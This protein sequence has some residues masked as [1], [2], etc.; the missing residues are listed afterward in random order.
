MQR[1]N[2]FVYLSANRHYLQ[3]MLNVLFQTAV[4]QV[5]NVAI[6]IPISK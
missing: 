4:G 5:E 6:P 2:G 3:P 1:Y